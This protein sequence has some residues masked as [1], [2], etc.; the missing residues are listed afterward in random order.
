MQ[1]N[2]IGSLSNQI[3]SNTTQ[4]SQMSNHTQDVTTLLSNESSLANKTVSSMEE[5]NAQVNSINEAISVIDQISFQ[6]NILSLNAAVEAATAGETGKGFAVVAQEVR[7][8]A[9]RSA[10]AANEIKKI[11]EIATFKA[12]EGKDI[13]NKMIEGFESLNNSIDTMTQTIQDVTSSSM[14]QAQNMQNINEA[15][16]NLSNDIKQSVEVSNKS[17]DDTFK[18][19]HIS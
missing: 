4:I 9:S 7:N 15:M 3:T 8:L 12:K 19:L 16:N 17:K 10:E 11:V 5:I 2:S 14:E 18:I 13:S 6:T 1:T